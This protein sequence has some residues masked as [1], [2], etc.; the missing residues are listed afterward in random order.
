MQRPVQYSFFHC[1]FDRKPYNLVCLVITGKSQTSALVLT[2]L[3]LGQYSKASVRDLPVMTS[4][5][6]NKQFIPE[7]IGI[8]KGTS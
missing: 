8:E 4:L 1:Y 2:L 3:L 7:Q 5:T 6:V